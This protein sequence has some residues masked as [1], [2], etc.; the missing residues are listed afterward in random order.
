MIISRTG[1]RKW[2]NR[3]ESFTQNIEDLYDLAD[4]STMDILADYNDVT[5]GIQQLMKQFIANGKRTRVLGGEWSWT[6]IAASDG[7]LLNTKPLNLTFRISLNNV[8]P[9]YAKSPDDLYFAQCGVS[10]QELSTRLR[11]RKRSLKTSGA[12]NGQTIAGALSTG[13]HGSAIDIGGVAD[14]VVGLHLIVSPTRHIWLERRSY[15][16]VSDVFVANLHAERVQDDALFNAALVSF[17][18]FGFI[19]GVMIETVPLFLY[20]SYRLSVPLDNTLYTLMESLSFANSFLPYGSER[21]YHFQVLVNQ[22][23]PNHKAYVTVMY[24]RDYEDNYIPPS[25]AVP[26][27][28]PGDDAPSFIGTISQA[29]PAVVPILVNAV[30]GGSYKPYSKVFG[31]HAE[32][33]SNTDLHGKVLSAAI[34]I[35]LSAVN[36]VRELLIDLN[37]HYGPFAGVLAFRFVKGTQATLGF[38]HFTTTCVVELDSVMSDETYRFYNKVWDELERQHIP[39]SFHWGKVLRLDHTRIRNMYGEEKIDNWIQARNTLMQDPE[40]MRLFTNDVMVLWGLDEIRSTTPVT[41]VV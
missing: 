30:I 17:G 34:G 7:I 37:T 18:C 35:P 40:S 15:P 13:T 19:H 27:I 11:R 23:D 21:P 38:T 29:L 26:G 12:S 22:Y 14:Y 20:E 9:A 1:A 25:M 8:S 6:K 2:V 41:P 39:H 3:H 24:K 33:F 10:I 4:E 31:T 36:Q 5:A 28:G 16:V 32:M